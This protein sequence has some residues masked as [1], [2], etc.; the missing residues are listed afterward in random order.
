MNQPNIAIIVPRVSSG[1][2][3]EGTSLDS[4]QEACL[5]VAQAENAH[6]CAIYR[7]EGV[8]GKLYRSRKGLQMALADIEA[9]RANLLITSK[10]DRAGRDV[11]VLRAIKRRVEAAGARLLFADGMNFEPTA[12]GRMMFTHLAGYAE[13]EVDL[14]RER[15]MLGKVRTVTETGKQPARALSPYGYHIV[16]QKDVLT[17][18]FSAEL[19][20]KYQIVEEEARWA[21]EIFRRYAG[22]SSLRQITRWLYEQGVPTPR[23]GNS[24]SMPTVKNII[25]NPAYKGQPVFGRFARRLDESRLDKGYLPAYYVRR[26]EA[27]WLR[28]SGP[29]IVT[30]ELWEACQ[31]RLAHNQEVFS[32]N[33]KHK[34]FLS[35]YMLCPT[36]G[37]RMRAN[38][39]VSGVVYYRCKKAWAG[40]KDGDA[41]HPKQYRADQADP[42]VLRGMSEA[43][44]R[45]ELF[46]QAVGAFDR[47][48]QRQAAPG[49]GQ[50]VVRR[51]LA[52]LQ[53]EE[54]ATVTAQIE[55]IKQ[56]A[57]P[58]V[59]AAIFADQAARRKELETRLEAIDNRPAP[60]SA[61][62]V[63]TAAEKYKSVLRDVD[64]A[65]SAPELSVAE[66]REIVRPILDSVV[67]GTDRYEVYLQPLQ[68]TPGMPSEKGI[69]IFFTCVASRRN[70]R[71]SPCAG[72]DQ[73]RSRP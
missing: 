5:R 72:S 11:E 34:H 7:D 55:G 13:Y 62:A 50:E 65:L 27:E 48:Q 22:G 45:P 4:Q 39:H 32:G 1:K 66:R 17:G 30:E 21:G 60:L 3:V 36:C 49:E 6:V 58:A 42:A 47:D 69:Q 38:T 35:G 41:C 64:E 52:E 56:G 37:N 19:L 14:T 57:N 43:A 67:P 71:D 63:R 33:P 29:A 54:R 70:S 12:V 15:T 8:S 16:S 46:D 25:Q 59:Y 23:N 18:Q 9:G 40:R 28:L 24:W 44:H 10:L 73:S 53:E 26:P 61:A 20:G 31:S 51:K 2:Q 68:S